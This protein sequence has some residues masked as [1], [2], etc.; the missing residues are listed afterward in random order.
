MA[1]VGRVI[2]VLA[3]LTAAGA[4][5]AAAARTVRL[6]LS[7]GAIGTGTEVA[8]HPR[9]W[10]TIRHSAAFVRPDPLHEMASAAAP[11]RPRSRAY[12]IT[13]DIHPFGGGLRLSL[14]LRQDNNHQLLRAGGDAAD[15]GTEHYAPL[16][17]IGFS[18]EI[19]EGFSVGGDVGLIGHDM[20][21]AGSGVLLTPVDL[22]RHGGGDARGYGPLLQ[23]SASYRF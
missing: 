17:S 19:A 11:A 8:Y 3:C 12:A 15:I 23:L 10:L 16:M 20:R 14:G 1:V 5:Q 6:P 22:E 7:L 4:G 13:G 2:L 21:R 18:G 9:R